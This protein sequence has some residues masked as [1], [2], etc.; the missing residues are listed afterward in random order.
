MVALSGGTLVCFIDDAKKGGTAGQPILRFDAFHERHPGMPVICVVSDRQRRYELVAMLRNHG[1][2][3]LTVV[4]PGAVVTP[5]TAVVKN[6][7]YVEPGAVVGAFACIGEAAQLSQ[8][9]VVCH[10]SVVGSCVHIAPNATVGSSVEI[11][12]MAFVGTGAV[13]ET[14]CRVG[15][16]AM[17]GPGCHLDTNL[18]PWRMVL[19]NGSK[20]KVR[21]KADDEGFIGSGS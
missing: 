20:G 6:G 2:P 4:C 17:V 11:G 19:R 13:V 8:G 14:G 16:G 12:D 3:L 18:D 9:A 7:A 10:H 15:E 5:W 21:R 1:H